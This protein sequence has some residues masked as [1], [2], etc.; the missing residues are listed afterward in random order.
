MQSES[1][2]PSDDDDL[3]HASSIPWVEACGSFHGT[4][5]NMEICKMTRYLLAK[6]T[7]M[8]HFPVKQRLLIQ[9]EAS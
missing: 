4:A 1:P 5:L 7:Q 3:M 8:S 6:K 2:A 9:G